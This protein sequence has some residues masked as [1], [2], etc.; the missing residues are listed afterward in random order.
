VRASPLR[1]ARDGRNTVLP[2]TFF[3]ARCQSK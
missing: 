1:P 2:V 3:T